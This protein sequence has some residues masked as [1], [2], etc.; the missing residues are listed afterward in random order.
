MRWLR[1]ATGSFRTDPDS[2]CNDHYVRV[3]VLVSSTWS[4]HACQR[5]RYLATLQTTNPLLKALLQNATKKP[6]WVKQII[7]DQKALRAAS[8][9]LQTLPPPAVN[10]DAWVKFAIQSR[11]S[12]R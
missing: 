5:L 4:L 9:K 6:Y 7:F 11:K 1:K 2:H 10:V 12:W 3:T 8:P